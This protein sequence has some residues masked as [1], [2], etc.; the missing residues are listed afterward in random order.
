[1]LLRALWKQGAFIFLFSYL[2]FHATMATRRRSMPTLSKDEVKT[3]EE[4]FP[5]TDREKVYDEAEN[6]VKKDKKEKD[7]KKKK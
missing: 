7:K 1:M 6:E 4:K 2:P 5:K 3:I